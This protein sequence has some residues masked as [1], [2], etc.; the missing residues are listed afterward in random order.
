MKLQKT[1]IEGIYRESSGALLN[2]DV[3]SLT[4]Y[5]KKK[6]AQKELENFMQ[7]T[8]ENQE[9]MAQLELA[10]INTNKCANELIAFQKTEI[11]H[12]KSD[13]VEIKKLLLKITSS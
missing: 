8:K 6:Q 5:K 1:E 11:E 10:Y 2:N 12:M 9:K 13:L 3:N 4:V 7:M